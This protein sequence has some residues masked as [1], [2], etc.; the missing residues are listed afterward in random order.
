M[1]GTDR[2]KEYKENGI[3]HIFNR[4]VAR[5]KIFFARADYLYYIRCLREAL[6]PKNVLLASIES[7]K[8][9]PQN[10]IQRYSKIARL[11]NHSK[12]INLYCYCLMPNHFH[13][14]IKQKHAR[15]MSSFMTSVQTR[16][17]KYLNSKYSRVGPVFQ[18]RYQARSISAQKTLLYITRYVHRNP[19]NIASLDDYPWSS[20]KFFVNRR[21]PMW[22]RAKKILKYYSTSTYYRDHKRYTSFVEG[23]L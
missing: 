23:S 12:N 8:L 15:N 19:I 18:G 20:Y 1:H 4:G 3:Y 2:Y 16:Y 13:L 11:K 7:S 5:E 9:T 21:Y 22:V 6:L 17:C 10:K 14:V